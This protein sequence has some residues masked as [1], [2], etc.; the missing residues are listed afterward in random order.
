M[1]HEEHGGESKLN[2]YDFGWS[3]DVRDHLVVKLRV[4]GMNINIVLDQY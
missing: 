1:Q 4:S 3:E 2:F